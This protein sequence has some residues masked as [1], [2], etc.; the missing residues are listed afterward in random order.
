M[1]LFTGISSIT[2]VFQEIFQHQQMTC[3]NLFNDFKENL[4]ARHV[5][6]MEGNGLIITIIII[7]GFV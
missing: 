2:S 7:I 6:G 3:F 4:V 1:V 5:T